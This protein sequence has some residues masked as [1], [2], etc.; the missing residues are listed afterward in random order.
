MLFIETRRHSFLTH[1]L[2][3]NAWIVSDVPPRH[4]IL[5]RPNVVLLKSSKTRQSVT[6]LVTQRTFSALWQ[7]TAPVKDARKGGRGS[8]VTCSSPQYIHVNQFC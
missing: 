4:W 3:C 5:A 2:L 1:L 8:P 7:Y 6:V